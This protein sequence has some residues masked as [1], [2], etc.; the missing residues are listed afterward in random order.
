[1]Q[2]YFLFQALYIWLFDDLTIMYHSDSVWL[3]AITYELINM[4]KVRAIS[5]NDSEHTQ[6]YLGGFVAK[7]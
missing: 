3:I 7:S 6:I 2:R 1:M 5:S 4:N